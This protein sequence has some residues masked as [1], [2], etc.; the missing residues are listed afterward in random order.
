MDTFLKS[1]Q[2]QLDRPELLEEAL[3]HSSYCNGAGVNLPSNERLEFLGDAVLGLAVADWLVK[4]R[5]YWEEGQLTKARSAVVSQQ[6]LV[7][8]AER[9]GIAPHIKM[10]KAETE[11]RLQWLPSVLS[12]AFEALV[13]AIYVDGGYVKV[14]DFVQEV[15]GE[16][17][18]Q[19]LQTGAST[20]DAKS[21]LQ[22]LTQEAQKELPVYETISEEGPDHEKVFTVSV[23]LKGDKLATGKGRSKRGAEQEAAAAALELLGQRANNGPRQ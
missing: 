5:P 8:V 4:R 13:G 1:L 2:S 19:A 7:V 20:E 21:R 16:A 17:L 14:R 10:G 15:L 9:L 22:I 11:G 3:R 12:C 23:S 18:E 6:G